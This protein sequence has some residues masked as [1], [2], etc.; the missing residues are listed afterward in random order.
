MCNSM[1][2]QLHEGMLFATLEVG[3]L[4]SAARKKKVER[5]NLP[6]APRLQKCRFL[7]EERFGVESGSAMD[8]FQLLHRI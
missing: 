7:S 5:M 2:P 3:K 1:Q 4:L 8:F 6:Q